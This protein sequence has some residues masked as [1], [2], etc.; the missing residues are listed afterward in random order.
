MK[1]FTL[2][3]I[4]LLLLAGCTTTQ[5]MDFRPKADIAGWCAHEEIETHTVFNGRIG[6]PLGTIDGTV[7]IEQTVLG[8]YDDE[9]C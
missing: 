7:R 4:P 2:I 1:L 3:F 6:S 9:T 5:I 8:V